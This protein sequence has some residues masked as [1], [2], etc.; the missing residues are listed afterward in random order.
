M[1]TQIET[2]LLTQ[3]LVTRPNRPLANFY[4]EAKV[5]GASALFKHGEEWQRIRRF[6]QTDML[7]PSAAKGY[8][9]GIIK[10][11]QIASEGAPLHSDKMKEYM[12]YA[13]FD[14]FSAVSLGEFPGLANGK[15]QDDDNLLFCNATV[16]GFNNEFPLMLNPLE[17]VKKSL[18]IKSSMY[19]NFEKDFGLARDIAARKVKDFWKRKDNGDLKNDF[20][21]NSYA[22]L[23]IDRYLSSIGTDDEMDEEDVYE[24]V[25]LGLIAALD[26]TSSVL[27]W[28]ILHLAMNPHVQEVLHEEVYENVAMAGAG[29]LTPE[30]FAKSS[31]T[32][33]DAV[34][35]ENHRMTPPFAVNLLK[36]NFTE[37][38][39]IHGKTIQ[40]GSIFVL[41]SYS[42]G[43][44]P[45]Y[46]D[47]PDVF[48]PSRWLED[49]VL[50]RK[51]TPQEKLD[52]ALYKQPFSAGARR[53]PGSRIAT[54]ESKVFLSQLVL[55]WKVSLDESET[56]RIQ[57]WRD[58]PY[59]QGLSIQPESPKLKF[60]KR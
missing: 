24:V 44:D 52:H 4:E 15:N 49:K 45:G 27:N 2:Y 28:S 32:Y 38:V 30:C 43:M 42:L 6:L 21:K 55:D 50:E 26:T 7:H 35:R 23:A 8:V 59:G 47:N 11:S 13:S 56:E 5:R 12:V 3:Q 9:P 34:L 19:K 37:D 29:T 51:G 54:H 41:D 36:T 31:N 14:M 1:P 17:K 22:S 18:G 16:D 60:E 58:I 25:M 20:E 39:E 53:C 40:K 48:D 46:V 33:L 10:A 57:S